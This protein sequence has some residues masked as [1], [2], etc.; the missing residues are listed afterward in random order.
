MKYGCPH[1][2][3]ANRTGYRDGVAEVEVHDAKRRKRLEEMYADEI[4]GGALFRG[5][6]DHADADRRDVFLQLAAAEERH[7]E[8]WARLLR[9]DGIEPKKPRLPFRVRGAVLPR[10]TVRHGGG[11]AA[12]V[13]HRGGGSRPLP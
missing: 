4:A 9:K 13:A 2:A 3:C 7:A 12:D 11:A 8:H 6:A 1:D 10:A 5:L